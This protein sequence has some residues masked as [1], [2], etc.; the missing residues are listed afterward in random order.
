MSMQAEWKHVDTV[1]LDMDGTLLDLSFDTY[2]WHRYVPLRYSQKN[3]MEFSHAKELLQGYYKGKSG[4]LD[5]YCTDYWTKKL[6][7]DLPA[8]KREIAGRIQLF[9]NAL[10]FLEKLVEAGKHVA[11]M[12]NAHPDSIAVKLESVRIEPYFDRIVSSHDFGCPKEQL[13]FWNRV[14]H[15]YSYDPRKTLFIDDNLAVLDAANAFGIRYLI[16]IQQPDSSK[17][18]RESLPYESISD[19]D[20]IMP[21]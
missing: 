2:F 21:D 16:T 14:M 1:F 12:T 15:S 4:T 17:P 6:G 7:L 10:R 5:W 11:L 8:L 20:E 19:F 3:G 13:D 9:P 18:K